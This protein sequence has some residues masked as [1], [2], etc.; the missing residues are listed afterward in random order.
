MDCCYVHS[1]IY[2]IVQVLRELFREATSGGDEIVGVYVIPGHIFVA[3][4]TA[5][6]SVIKEGDC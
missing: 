1:N 6:T 4:V 3:T 5:T 2:A